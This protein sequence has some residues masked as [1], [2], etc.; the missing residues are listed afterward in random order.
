MKKLI[1]LI[2]AVCCMMAMASIGFAEAADTDSAFTMYYPAHLQ[3]QFGATTQ[4]DKV[5]ERIVCLSN[6]ALQVLARLDIHPVAITSNATSGLP[7]WVYEL[8]TISVGMKSLDVE[9][10]ISYEPDLVILG[11]YQKE[12]YGQNFEDAGIDC[13]YTSE[14]PSIS[15]SQTKDETL[16]LAKSF[17]GDEFEA[18]LASEFEAVEQRCADFTATH[19]TQT[20]MIFFYQPGTY[21]QTSKGYLCSMLAML[22]FENLTDSLVDGD[23]PTTTIDTEITLGLNPDI[24]FA[25]SPSAPSAEVLQ[26]TFEATFDENRTLW[27]QLDAVANNNIVYLG[28]E[29]VTSKGLQSISSI[30]KLVDLLEARIPAAQ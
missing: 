26:E 20:M 14:G 7:D 29:Y 9:S 5:P 21:Q 13:F 27:N 6:T 10:I 24:I 4:L 15:Y 18:E 17:G 8:P 28:G 22:P 23:S 12:A 2:L 19:E 16:C 30:N 25:I 11:S 1:S 3:E